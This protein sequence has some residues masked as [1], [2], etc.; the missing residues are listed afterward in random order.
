M[1]NFEGQVAVV[2]GAS[3]EGG[4]GWA[5]AEA[6]AKA[7]AKVVV[8]ARSYEPLKRLADKIGGLAVRCDGGSEADITALA[9]A[10][11]AAY[12]RIDIAVNS[13]ATPTL[14]LINEAT[15]ELMMQAVQVNFIGMTYFVRDMA[16]RM[17]NGG[18]MILISSMTATHPLQPHFAYAC[19]KAAT[20]CLVKYAAQEFGPQGI[21]VNGIRI[22]TSVSDMAGD[23]FNTP[24]VGEQFAREVPLGRLGQ[25]EDIADAALWLAGPAYVSG[26]TIDVSGGNQMNR[27]PFL[28][29]LPG[30][31]KSYEG[32]AALYD[33][34]QGLGYKPAG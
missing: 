6:L 13:A 7:G 21:R 22:A 18:S 25:P 29:D 27:F 19:A 3:A 14:G 4:T 23:F 15:P 30:A 31:D 2:L 9:E 5:I 20:E 34:E 33:R 32:S 11:I 1:R 28:S 26:L 24:G 17:T 8:G 16:A 12:G 10:A